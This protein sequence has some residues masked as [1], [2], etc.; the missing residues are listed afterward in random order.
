VRQVCIGVQD[1]RPVGLETAD[2]VV[3]GTGRAVGDDVADVRVL[4]CGDY[5]IVG[6]DLIA[7]RWLP[8]LLAR[9]YPVVPV[10]AAIPEFRGSW[11]RCGHGE[12]AIPDLSRAF[13]G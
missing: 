11:H 4:P 5:V 1:E 8:G 10:H 13:R 12:G 3:G 9:E 6:G 7:H 2:D